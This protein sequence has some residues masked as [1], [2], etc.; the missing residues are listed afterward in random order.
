MVAT[1][2]RRALGGLGV[3]VL[4]PNVTPGARIGLQVPG[5]LNATIVLPIV[6]AR[7]AYRHEARGKAGG[8][9]ALLI[10]VQEDATGL[11]DF[12]V[13]KFGPARVLE[14]KYAF[15]FCHGTKIRIMSKKRNITE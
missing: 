6:V 15:L 12:L 3:A 4:T 8:I 5:N 2:K 9:I 10:I 1:V 14:P 13:S 7:R 11:L